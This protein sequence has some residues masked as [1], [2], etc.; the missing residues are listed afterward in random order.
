VTKCRA[1]GDFMEA[2]KVVRSV[3]LL[4]LLV[5]VVSVTGVFADGATNS[6]P[7]GTVV[8]LNSVQAPNPNLLQADLMLPTLLPTGPIVALIPNPPP[9]TTP[10]PEPSSVYL[11]ML[12]A[13]MILFSL[14]RRATES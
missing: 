10:T 7:R 14:K 2:R 8:S 11:F 4:A 13:G 5:L 9:P 1:L 3:S 6:Q 12:G